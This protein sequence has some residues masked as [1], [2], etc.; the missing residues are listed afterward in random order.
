MLGTGAYLVIADN[1]PA[2]IMIAST[3]II[4][5]AIGPV[6]GAI[7]GWRSFVEVRN[8]YARLD[9]LFHEQTAAGKPD[10]S[11]PDIRGRVELNGVYYGFT[12][13]SVLIGNATVTIEAGEAVGI[14]GSSGS[15]KSTL[16]RLILGLARPQRGKVLIDGYD[17]SQYERTAL[18]PQLGYLP[19]D[20]K[21]FSGSLARNIARMEDPEEHSEEIVRVTEQVRLAPV[22][23]RLPGGFQYALAENG[24]N[25]SGGQRQLVGLARALF[26]AP[27]LIVLDEPDAGL[28]QE[29][30]T[31]LLDIIGTLVAARETTLIVISHNARIIER[32]DRLLMIQDGAAKQL[33]RKSAQAIEASV[34]PIQGVS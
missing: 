32:M 25:L 19:Q 20:V 12:P 23:A 30:Q 34:V 18:G 24:A 21:L 6:E 2:G 15:G 14:V 3:I 26:G 4:G 10:V 33:V 1:L 13:E 9:R 27:R 29:G 31:Q 17:V 8:A 5:R 16:V 7:T 28:D 22:L 11:L